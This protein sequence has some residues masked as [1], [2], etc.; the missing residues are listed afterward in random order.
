MTTLTMSEADAGTACPVLVHQAWTAA[1]SG[2]RWNKAS[3]GSM[4]PWHSGREAAAVS[5]SSIAN[6]CPSARHPRRQPSST[7]SPVMLRSRRVVPS[8]P[9]S[10]VKLCARAASETTGDDISVPSSDHVP[11]LMNAT[12]GPDGIEA[13]ADPVS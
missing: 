4:T 2:V 6:V 9:P 11:E 5:R 13:T 10:F 1:A 3:S 7:Q 8:T 12:P